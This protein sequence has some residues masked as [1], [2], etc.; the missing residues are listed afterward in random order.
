M[1]NSSNFLRRQLNTED[2]PS[3]FVPYAEK[4]QQILYDVTPNVNV[5]IRTWEVDRGAQIPRNNY[6][7]SKLLE[8]RESQFN[9]VFNNKTINQRMDL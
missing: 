2:E 8:L 3:I 9:I 6:D 5:F 1:N 4:D 7:I